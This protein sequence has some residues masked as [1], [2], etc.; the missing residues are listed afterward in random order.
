VNV[1]RWPRVV[2][3]G[4]WLLAGSTSVPRLVH[5]PRH[6]PVWVAAFAAFGVLFWVGTDRRASKL[7]TITC[8][9][10]EAALAGVLDSIG[11]PAFEGAPFALVAAQLPLVLPVAVTVAWALAQAVVLFLVLPSA[12]NAV[13]IA[14]SVGSY[15]GFATLAVVLV[16][17]FDSERRARVEL[18]RAGERVR[19]ARDLHDVLGHHLA[20]LTVQLDLARR[21]AEGDAKTPLEQ[22]HSTARK[23]LADVRG[24]VTQLRN[25][26]YD[27]RSA[28][29]A[30]VK[31]VTEPPIQVTFPAELKVSDAACAHVALRCIQE[32]ITNTVKHAHA[33]KVRV[34][35]SRQGDELMLTIEDDG[36]AAGAIQPGNGLRGM[37]E[38]IEEL[39][40]ALDVDSVAQRGTT[41]RARLPMSTERPA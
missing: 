40:G 3:V 5:D 6:A 26:E 33:K 24:A 22:A 34:V 13:E 27:L 39:G 38:R 14:K 32:A 16:R 7:R 20:A 28:L 30:V 31:A 2:S 25:D 11:M 10:L 19:I 15:L 4:V 35:L 12:Y 17:L 23:M 37:R 21:K 36:A 29:D 18:A 41:V 9:V 1:P 8:L